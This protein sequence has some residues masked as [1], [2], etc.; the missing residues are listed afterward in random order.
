MT[1]YKLYR[2]SIFH[3]IENASNIEPVYFQDGLMVVSKGRIVEVGV[4]SE[5]SSR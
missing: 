4:Y 2:G 5:L 1:D 3:C